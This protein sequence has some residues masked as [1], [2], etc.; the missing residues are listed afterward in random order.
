MSDIILRVSCAFFLLAATLSGNWGVLG[1]VG[2]G[3]EACSGVLCPSLHSPAPSGVSWDDYWKQVEDTRQAIVELEQIPLDEACT[4]LEAIALQWENLTS[5]ALPDGSE[6]AIDYSYMISLLRDPQPDLARID[7]LL[8]S[9]LAE[10]DNFSQGPYTAGDHES[11]SRILAQPEFQWKEP[12]SEPQSAL[13]KLWQRIQKEL[14]LLGSQLFDSEGANIIFGAGAVLLLAAMLLVL[15]RKVLFGFV[16]EARLAPRARTGDEYLSAD[17]AF[18]RAQDLSLGGDYRS[19]VRYLY[20][21]ALLLLEER[22][23]LSYDRTKT[24]REY[25]LSLRD[26]PEL[27]T[28]L[29]QVVEVFDRVW[30]G[31]QPLGD[32]DYHYYERQV[33][34]LR[35]LRQM[36]PPKADGG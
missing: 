16:A 24:N 22:G 13:E 35:Q 1:S 5:V 27:E 15:L 8:L 21:S 2:A 3:S 33:G 30:Y 4:R 17:S 10:R 18:K 25:L 23:L 12:N 32:Q 28:P 29:Q 7:H 31:Y 9:L 19:A 6:M 20:L 36:I 11:L 14:G 26:Q 34:K